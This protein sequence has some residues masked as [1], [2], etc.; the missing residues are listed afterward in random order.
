MTSRR[1]LSLSQRL[2]A[3]VTGLLARTLTGL[4]WRYRCCRARSIAVA[5]FVNSATVVGGFLTSPANSC[6]FT[7]RIRYCSFL[8]SGISGSALPKRRVMS[9]ANIATLSLGLRIQASK[10]RFAFSFLSRLLKV[11]ISWLRKSSHVAMLFSLLMY[12]VW[13]LSFR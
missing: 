8:S 4:C 7:P 13:A 6:S 9:S 1:G 12:H 11:S 5:S 3:V 10:R 2:A